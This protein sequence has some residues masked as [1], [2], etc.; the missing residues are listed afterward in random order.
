MIGVELR[1]HGEIS[2]NRED[3]FAY[4]SYSSKDMLFGRI[5]SRKDGMSEKTEDRN[6]LAGGTYADKH[7]LCNEQEYVKIWSR[8]SCTWA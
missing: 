7:M 3:T 8:S 6:S 1:T 4:V 2:S 5:R